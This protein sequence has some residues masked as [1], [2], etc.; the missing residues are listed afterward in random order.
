MKRGASIK[1]GTNS[2]QS[3]LAIYQLMK[4][5]KLRSMENKE[6]KQGKHVFAVY[7]SKDG[8]LNISNTMYHVTEEAE[9][10]DD[11]R[12]SFVALWFDGPN[13]WND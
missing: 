9:A 11:F 8:K 12:E 2:K 3:Q 4:L 5:N 7:K 6:P 13:Y 1:A 10:R